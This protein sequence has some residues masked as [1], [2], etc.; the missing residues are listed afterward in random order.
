MCSRSK[1]EQP[2]PLKEKIPCTIGM[3]TFN[4]AQ[5]IRACLDSVSAFSEIIVGDGNSTDD[6]VT[7]ARSYGAKVIK[8][9]DTDVPETEC[10]KDKA[11]VRQRVMDQAT[12]E[13]FFFMDSDDELSPEA[14]E[15]IRSIVTAESPQHLIYRMPTRI[16]MDGKEILHEATYPAYQT[17]L[18]HRSVGATFRGDIHDRLQFDMA[19][20]PVGTMRYF[21]DFHWD[22]DRIRNYRRYLTRYATWETEVARFRSFKEFLYWGIYRRV[23]I[24]LGYL[25]YRLPAMYLRY[26]FKNSM[27]LWV[28]FEIVRYHILIL[29]GQFW[30]TLRRLSAVDFLFETLKG[31]DLYRIATNQKVRDMPLYGKTLDIG[32]DRKS[33]YY[34][35]LSTAKWNRISYL[36]IA[37]GTHPDIRIDVDAEDIPAEEGTYDT[38]LMFNLLEHLARGGHALAESRR[39]LREDG[40]LIGVVPFLVGVHE[41]P[42]DY[43]R[44]AHDGLAALLQDAGFGR[45]EI[46]PIGWGPFTAGYHQVEFLLPRLLRL[47][48]APCAICFDRLATLVSRRDMVRAYPLAYFFRAR[49]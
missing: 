22:A 35:Y 49:P 12:E 9:Y 31:K 46:Q 42:R 29:F 23:R 45:A 41:D 39:V 6:T 19:K 13:W 36:N 1:S 33:S 27:P 15:E 17:R 11:A 20:Y 14:V 16:F 34:R 25:L 2:M 8:Q 18:V 43:V 21:Y 30:I 26:G 10:V 28:E 40:V 7:I 4:S 48:L 38:V 24:I 37:P 3:L 47:I 5:G 44:Y 32:G